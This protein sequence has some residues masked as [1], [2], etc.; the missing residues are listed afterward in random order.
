MVL[1]V[2]KN[3]INAKSMEN[4]MGS[5]SMDLSSV[6]DRGVQRVK[7]RSDFDRIAA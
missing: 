4:Q 5:A 7:Q 2:L 3:K 1:Q 6:G